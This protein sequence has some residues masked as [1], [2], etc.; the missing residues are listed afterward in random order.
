MCPPRSPLVRFD[1]AVSP[2]VP[3]VKAR[4]SHVLV[5]PLVNGKDLGPFILDTGASGL[6]IS[7]SAADA[8][9]L[10]AFGEVHVSGVNG[11]VPCRF[12]RGTTVTLGP[13]IVDKP[14]FMEMSL[15]GIVSGSPSPVAGIIGFDAF[16]SVRQRQQRRK[17]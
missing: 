12:R 10:D 9:G 7:K 11:K 16:K 6:V 17:L 13:L 3:V 5:R 15:E 1:A 8:V 4:S 14:V 2:V